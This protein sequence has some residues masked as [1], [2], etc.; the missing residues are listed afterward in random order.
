MFVFKTRYIP[1]A[2]ILFTIAEIELRPVIYWMFS[3]LVTRYRVTNKK[4]AKKNGIS[5]KRTANRKGCGKIM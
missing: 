4:F 3:N 2:Q 1:S 5:Q